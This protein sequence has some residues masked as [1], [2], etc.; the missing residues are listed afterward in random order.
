DVEIEDISESVAALALQGPTS[1]RLLKTVAEDADI[2]S[3]KY[4]RVTKGKIAGVPVEISRTG[5][6]G[7][8]GYEIWVDADQALKI[9]DVLFDW[10][11][12]GPKLK[13]FMKKLVCR[14]PSRRWL[15][16]SPFQFSI[17][18]RR[19]GRPRQQPGRR[20]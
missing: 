10:K 18:A 4:F 3:L 11:S 6:T 19:L 9:W 13:S 5:Y 12:I 2:A 8:L 17:M 15:R 1:A 14:P 20:F 16:A 7:D